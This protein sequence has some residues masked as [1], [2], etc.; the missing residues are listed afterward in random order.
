MA[1]AAA[2]A[3]NASPLREGPGDDAKQT[4]T[5][6]IPIAWQHHRTTFSYFGVT[7]LYSCDG[8]EEQV[9]R[10]LLY[11]GARGDLKVRT[12]GCPHGPDA[13][14][15]NAWVDVDFHAPVPAG[16][17][18]AD[19]V[20][21]QWTRME[22]KPRHPSFLSEGDCELMQDMK[23]LV[24]GSFTVRDIDYRASCFPNPPSI[25][26]FAVKGLTLKV[27]APTR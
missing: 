13:P 26:G 14:T 2:S 17:G 8:L 23:D 24:T 5:D 12:R 3:A 6:K 16:G 15:H 22:L 4:D 7:V 19:T 18:S 20:M 1:L 9:R 25:D 11:L 27:A 10:I 21:A